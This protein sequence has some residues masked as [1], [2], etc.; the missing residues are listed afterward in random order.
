MKFES[1]HSFFHLVGLKSFLGDFQKGGKILE[2]AVFA[3]G[4]RIVFEHSFMNLF[5]KGSKIVNWKSFLKKLVNK[6]GNFF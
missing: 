2:K 4:S 6:L 1:A 3:I 5:L